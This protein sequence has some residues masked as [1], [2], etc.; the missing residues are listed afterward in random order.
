MARHLRTDVIGHDG[1]AGNASCLGAYLSELGAYPLLTRD[2][3]VRLGAL[4][5]H[6]L[7]AARELEEGATGADVPDLEQRVADGRRAAQRF[8]QSNLRLVV[9]IAR[10]YRSASLT[11][12]DLIQE[13]NLGLMHAVSRFDPWRG[14]RFSTYARYWIHQAIT[15]AVAE[16]GQPVRVPVQ[17]MDLAWRVRRTQSTLEVQRGRSQTV[18]EVAD[19]VGLPPKQ[20]ESLLSYLHEPRSLSESLG[21]EHGDELGATIADP[22]SHAPD[23]EVVG[24]AVPSA[25]RRLLESLDEREQEILRRHFGL[26]GARPQTLAEIGAAYRLTRE[27]IRQIEARALEKLRNPKDS[28]AQR[29]LAMVAG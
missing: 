16:H 4:V 13:G 21:D 3:E 26:D 19:E 29:A 12:L 28:E 11:L 7:R 23:D 2:D 10:R 18:A 25:V 15:K 20:V 1:A 8:I 14:F 27:R 9:A 6:G 22:R 24:A 5:Q 17:V